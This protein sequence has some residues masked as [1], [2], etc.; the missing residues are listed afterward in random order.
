MEGLD[1]TKEELDKMLKDVEFK[2]RDL[3]IQKAFIKVMLKEYKN[4]IMK[5]SN[6]IVP[7]SSNFNT[8]TIP[9]YVVLCSKCEEEIINNGIHK[10]CK[11]YTDSDIKNPHRSRG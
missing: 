4:Q 1:F 6:F 10:V 7:T 8:T 11:C 3:E 2:M 5:K 9:D